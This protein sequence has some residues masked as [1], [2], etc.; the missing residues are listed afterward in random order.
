MARSTPAQNDR[1][2]ARITFRRPA[3]AAHRASAGPACRSERSAATPPASVAGP[4]GR[5]A[6]SDTARITTAGRSAAA[7]SSPADSRSAAS[8]PPAASRSRPAPRTSRGVLTT[9][10][11]TARSPARRSSPASSGADGQLISAAPPVTRDTTTRSPG[12]RLADSPPPVPATA[13]I[14]KEAVRNSAAADSALDGPYPVRRTS[15]AGPSPRR[16]A[17]ASIRSGAHTSSRFIGVLLMSRLQRRVAA[18]SPAA[19]QVAAQRA[20]RED[21]PVQVVVDIEVTGEPGASE[22]RLVPAAVRALGLRQPAD[23]PL[24]RGA[25]PVPGRQQ[26]EQRPG[27]LRRGR[28]APPGP[29][30]IVVGAEVLT[31][32]AVRVLVRFQPRHRPADARLARPHAGRDQAGHHRAGTVDVVRAPPAEP[33]PVAFLRPQQ[34]GHTAAH[35][36]AAGQPLGGQGL[37]RVRRDV[38]RRR[39]DDLTEVAERQLGDQPLDVVRVEGAPAAVLGLHPG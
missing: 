31:P 26:R 38:R 23:A 10:P 29:A 8:A 37:D 3:A 13:S 33:R 16:T 32:A 21:H 28:L 19:C 15:P 14:P 9:G 35:R 4:S 25:V 22:L 17:R 5:A 6:V 7:V 39:V 30:R 24:G 2:P 12:C 18:T 36:L 34:P 11:A 1:G 20:D 27:G